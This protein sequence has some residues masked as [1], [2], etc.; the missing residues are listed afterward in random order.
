LTQGFHLIL[1]FIWK[2][3][4]VCLS[5]ETNAHFTSMNTRYT[6]ERM[7]SLALPG[8]IGPV[9]LTVNVLPTEFQLVVDIERGL[10]SLI[11]APPCEPAS[12]ARIVRH[13]E[14]SPNGIRVAALLLKESTYCP[15]EYLLAALQVPFSVIH[16][17]LLAA[18]ASD[19]P[20][21][22]DLAADLATRINEAVPG[23]E[24]EWLLRQMRRTMT[25][26][27]KGLK[28][29]GL[30]VFTLRTLG[31]RLQQIVPPQHGPGV[32]RRKVPGGSGK[33]DQVPISKVA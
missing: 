24:R 31:Y 21:F 5:S 10:V 13:Q 17:G 8:E 20:E 29:F 12:H 4:K 9:H 15:F 16:S 32:P 18:S 33:A 22:E 3:E 11:Y 25:E 23:E 27:T 28:A 30:S 14:F 2:G 19:V 26:V 6:E 1:L 7:S